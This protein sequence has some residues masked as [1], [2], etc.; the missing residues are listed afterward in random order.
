MRL[1]TNACTP[2]Q[3]LCKRY[4][5]C[6]W[7]CHYRG[8]RLRQVPL[9]RWKKACQ[10]I[11]LKGGLF[12]DLRRTA[13]R[14]MVRTGISERVAMA[15]SGHK[16][17]SVFDR[18]DIVSEADLEGAKKKLEVRQPPKDSTAASLFE[19][20]SAPHVGIER[21]TNCFECAT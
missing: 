18:Y 7:V 16:T 17:R 14:N 6:N 19:E 4:L 12:H 13:V 10:R 21:D 5:A 9:K 11:G 20:T 3:D 15:I 2:Y 1:P 8:E